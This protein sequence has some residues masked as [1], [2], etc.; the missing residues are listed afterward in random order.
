MVMYHYVRDLPNT[1]FPGIKGMLTRD[2]E[3]QVDTLAGHYEMA[4]LES[5]LAFLGGRYEPKRNLCLLTFDDG[6]KDHF[7]DVLPILAERNIQGLFFVVTSCLE[8]HRVLSVHKNHFLMAALDFEEYRDGVLNCLAELS[9]ETGAEVDMA[10]AQRTYRWDTPEVAALKYLLNFRLPEA[11]RDRLLDM[12]FAQY[13][14]DEAEFSRQLYLSWDE[15]REMQSKGQVIGGHTHT[16]VPLAKLEDERQRADLEKCAEIL[17]E[18]VKSQG[19]WPFSYPYGKSDTFNPF[20]IQTLRGLGFAC[21]FS[22]EVGTNEVK[23]DP[24]SIRRIDPK[25][26]GVKRET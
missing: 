14:G 11:L 10:A 26:V 8:E 20:T 17:H 25:D 5:M 1:P 9:P 13:L 15:A 22:T 16:H 4:T 19:L 12:L 21:S 24:Y 18:R 23:T 6:L 3:E 2:F 7:T